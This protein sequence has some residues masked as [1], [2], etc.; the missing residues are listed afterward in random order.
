MDGKTL[1]IVLTKSKLFRAGKWKK[2]ARI[3]CNLA[4]SLIEKVDAAY[5]VETCPHVQ[6]TP[7]AAAWLL[8]G[9]QWIRD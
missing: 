8:L 3:V 9:F 5:V 1:S 2:T 4:F 7:A 6:I